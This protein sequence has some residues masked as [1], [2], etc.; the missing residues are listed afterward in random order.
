MDDVPN[1]AVDLLMKDKVS[2]LKLLYIGPIFTS[3]LSIQVDK[4]AKQTGEGG[5]RSEN[6]I[7]ATLQQKTYHKGRVQGYFEE[8]RS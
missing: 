8:V 5:G 7:K 4:K 2:L 6:S 3:F 1:S